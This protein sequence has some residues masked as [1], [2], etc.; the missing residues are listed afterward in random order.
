MTPFANLKASRGRD[1]IKKWNEMLGVLESL[2]PRAGN[3]I[4]LNT[5][6]YGTIISALVPKADAF[7]HPF[8]VERTQ[9]GFTVNFGVVNGIEPKIKGV[10][11]SGEA[12]KQP[13]YAEKFDKDG[14]K[15]IVLE[16]PV[17]QA[18]EIDKQAGIEVKVVDAPANEINISGTSKLQHVIAIVVVKDKV[19]NLFQVSYFNLQM[20]AFVKEDKSIQFL[21][22]AK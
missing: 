2:T 10:N 13:E 17:T 8:R 19:P 4:A 5:T 12:G 6:P 21:L 18:H 22:Y 16:I 15:Y 14:Q 1:I 7:S 3:N 11:I 9:K 20:Q